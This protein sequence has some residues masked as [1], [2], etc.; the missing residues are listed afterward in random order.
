MNLYE[1]TGQYLELQAM[2]E[3]PEVDSEVIADT[4]ESLEG[5]I[6]DKA[7]G[8]AKIIRNLEGNASAITA[9]MQRLAERIATIEAGVKRLKNNLQ[10]AMVAMDKRKIKTDLF[11]FS[12]QKNGG[13]LP[14]ILDVKSTE[15][16][17]DDLVKVKEEPDMDAIRKLLETKG[18]CQYAHFGE[19]GESLR[20][21]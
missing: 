5:D 15:E 18:E 17:P 8:Y 11:T 20:I 9:E 7:D 13:K 12:V 21:K 10:Q 6:E 4:M 3:D 19:R 2:L 16:L 14:V 1:L